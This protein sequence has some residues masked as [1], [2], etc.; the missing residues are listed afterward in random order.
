MQGL[1]HVRWDGE[2]HIARDTS[3]GQLHAGYPDGS[4]Y[5]PIAESPSAVVE[6]HTSLPDIVNVFAARL[7]KLPVAAISTTA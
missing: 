2:R 7:A 3:S 6:G 1:E 5:T 4:G